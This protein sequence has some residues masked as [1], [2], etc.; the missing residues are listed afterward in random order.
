[1]QQHTGEH[2]FSGIVNSL[3]GYNNVGFHL[4]SEVVTL[5]FD[6]ELKEDDI[7]KVET[8]VNKAIWNNLEIKVTFPSDEELER[9]KYR[10]KIE[11]E[12]HL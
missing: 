6:G 2:I 11:I 12:G 7:C 8:L 4:G 9:I 3:Y 1:M 5:D 10:S